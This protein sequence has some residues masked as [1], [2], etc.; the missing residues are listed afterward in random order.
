M[1][2]LI[3]AVWTA[4]TQIDTTIFW[5][6]WSTSSIGTHQSVRKIIGRP[7]IRWQTARGIDRPNL[8][9]YFKIP[10]SFFFISPSVLRKTACFFFCFVLFL[11]KLGKFE[12]AASE[13]RC[14]YLFI[15]FKFVASSSSAFF[16]QQDWTKKK[17]INF[18]YLLWFLFLSLSTFCLTFKIISVWSFWHKPDSIMSQHSA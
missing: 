15:F 12:A 11:L 13:A 2:T 8:A 7:L 17:K 14:H 3:S 1:A 16:R 10:F 18:K 9:V 5:S 6:I 4:D